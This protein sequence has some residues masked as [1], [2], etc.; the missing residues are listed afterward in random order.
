MKRAWCVL[1][2]EHW[3]EDIWEEDARQMA[4]LGLT[5]VR[6][7]EFSWSRLEP[8]EGQFNFEWLDRAFDTLHR[9][10]LKVVLGTPRQPAE[11]G[12]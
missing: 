3:P 12:L 9:H 7:G 8:S 1:L 4:E 2:S 5:W 11:M 10:G 6:I